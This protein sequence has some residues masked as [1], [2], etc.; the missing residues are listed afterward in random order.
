MFGIELSASPC[1]CGVGFEYCGVGFEFCFLESLLQ[2]S[3]GND[4]QNSQCAPCLAIIRVPGPAVGA[5]RSAPRVGMRIAPAYA[6]KPGAH[7]SFGNVNLSSH[8]E[9]L[10]YCN[11]NLS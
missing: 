3:A 4:R 8:S 2:L 1:C 5:V 7:C 10:V 11:E 9:A 6:I